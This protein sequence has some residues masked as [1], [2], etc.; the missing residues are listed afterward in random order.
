MQ[1]NSGLACARDKF[2]AAAGEQYAISP[3]DHM[4][5]ERV[6]FI[7]APTANHLLAMMADPIEQGLNNSSASL[8]A[9]KHYWLHPDTVGGKYGVLEF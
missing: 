9:S 1:E 3:E 7:P 8:Q 2:F 4:A 6:K 5:D